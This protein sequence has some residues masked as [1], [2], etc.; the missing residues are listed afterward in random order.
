MLLATISSMSFAQIGPNMLFDLDPRDPPYYVY[1]SGTKVWLCKGHVNEHILKTLIPTTLNGM[2]TLSEKKGGGK[3]KPPLKLCIYTPSS[4][5]PSMQ[6]FS[7]EQEFKK[8]TTG[9]GGWGDTIAGAIFRPPNNLEV[10][11]AKEYV[12]WKDYSSGSPQ[13]VLGGCN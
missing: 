4:K 10:S 12:C 6:F 9:C 11:F 1:E 13:L 2:A 3:Y 5:G 7:S 8:C